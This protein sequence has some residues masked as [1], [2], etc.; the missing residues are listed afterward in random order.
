MFVEYSAPEKDSQDFKNREIIARMVNDHFALYRDSYKYFNEQLFNPQVDDDIAEL[1]GKDNS[2]LR[3]IKEIDNLEKFE[4]RDEGW[5]M[6][7]DRFWEFS[8][9]Y[10]MNYKTFR[11][12]K[13]Q[14]GKNKVKLRKALISFYTE[15]HRIH[16]INRDLF[17]RTRYYPVIEDVNDETQKEK[18]V[19]KIDEILSRVNDNSLTKKNNI[20]L[21]ISVNYADF[22]LCSTSESWSSCLSLQTDYE[23]AYWTGLPGLIGDKSRVLIYITDGK[24]KEFH[25]IKVDSMMCRTWGILCDDGKIHLLNWYPQEMLKAKELNE[26]FDKKLFS[27]EADFTSKRP[28]YPLWNDDG[29]SVFIYQDYTCF[30]PEG[31]IANGA[32][33]HGYFQ[34]FS[35]G[36]PYF[37]DL[38]DIP[39]S[40]ESLMQRGENIED[41]VYEG[42][43]ICC[44]CGDIIQY[45]E[46]VEWG[47]DNRPYCSSCFDENYYN[48]E[49]GNTAHRDDLVE[50]YGTGE[51]YCPQ[52]ADELVLSEH[53]QE[54][55]HKE[56]CYE[57]KNE[58]GTDA[59]IFKGEVDGNDEY[60][61]LPNGMAC[62]TEDTIELE[63]GT[64]TFYLYAVE[65]G[66]AVICKYSEKTVL[67]SEA[68]YLPEVGGWVSND[69]LE[70]YRDSIQLKLKL[71]IA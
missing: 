14:V 13:V 57:F 12:G 16:F 52:C 44:D 42:S 41:Y 60:T 53:N 40:F 29:N 31:Y 11:K 56:R 15:G 58:D 1:I 64:I 38:Y 49:C 68:T 36:V 69:E 47:P 24:Q 61:I 7:K 3:L 65:D 45:E 6:F 34:N 48:C 21:V 50:D 9:F 4:G 18:I 17:Q 19:K 59:F 5:Q 8:M 70:A 63:D 67:K 30:T 39:E 20:K 22:F 37:G 51:Y 28:V 32:S 10:H 43:E 26:I 2:S 71:G 27:S 66:K 35:F 46:D 62:Y 33:G 54:L 25:G 55:Y 23:Y